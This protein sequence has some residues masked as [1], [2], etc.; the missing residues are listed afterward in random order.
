MSCDNLAANSRMKCGLCRYTVAAI[1]AAHAKKKAGARKLCEGLDADSADDAFDARGGPPNK[2]RGRTCHT[3]LSNMARSS[4][5]QSSPAAHTPR[6]PS[7]PLSL[8]PSNP[9]TLTRRR[10]ATEA[11][12]SSPPRA[13]W[14][15]R[16]VS[17]RLLLLPSLGRESKGERGKERETRGQQDAAC[18]QARALHACAAQAHA[19]GAGITSKNAASALF[20]GEHLLHLWRAHGSSMACQQPL[21]GALSQGPLER[22]LKLARMRCCQ[23]H[24]L[25]SH[26]PQAVGRNQ[27]HGSV[28][29]HQVLVLLPYPLHLR[30][31]VAVRHVGGGEV[32]LQ[33]TAQGRR[34][35]VYRRRVCRFL[36]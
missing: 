26:P 36:G 2:P 10:V 32:L 20:E 18:W 4:A 7:L 17:S 5:S 16:A 24:H 28:R 23:D 34:S 29:V 35:C 12:C 14:R 25:L 9:D 30:Q 21:Q 3:P 8:P 33:H 31:H 27:S 1:P 15:A 19:A 13:H 22:F 6:R 11:L